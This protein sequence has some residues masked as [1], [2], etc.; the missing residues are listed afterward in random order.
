MTTTA[1][2]DGSAC[3]P[4]IYPRSEALV[5]ATRDLARGRTTVEA[6]EARRRDDRQRLLAV[7]RESGL[8]PLSAGMLDW[9][10]IFRPLVEAS[11]GL[12]AGA[13]VRFLDGNTFY[14]AVDADG[15][16]RLRAPLAAPELPEPWL[17]TLPSP[18]ALAHAARHALTAAALAEAVLAPQID[19]WARA[20]CTL[21][22]LAEPFLP[23][24]PE[25][26]DELLAALERLPRPVPVALQ[27][28]FADASPLLAPLAEAAVD[29]VGID[30]RATP[31]EALPVGFPKAVLAGVV[32]ATSSLLE[33]PDAL[34]ELARALRARHPAALVLTPNGELEHV[35][36][37]IAHEKLRRLGAAA[38]ALREHA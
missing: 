7:Q 25:R 14:R 20:G 31:L 24:Q 16:P 36:E 35:P 37:T 32:D 9:Q 1:L 23:R 22:V 38:V 2:A 5:Q 6:V 10:D 26:V 13:L 28:T 17:A 27:L 21:V 30:F 19:T 29:A 33:Q 3:A 18:F 12:E 15:T 8:A 4:G 11:D 34:A